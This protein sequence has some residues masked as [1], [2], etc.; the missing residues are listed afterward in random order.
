MARRSKKT[1]LNA[2]LSPVANT[3]TSFAMQPP[4]K[5]RMKVSS[6]ALRQIGEEPRSNRRRRRQISQV[7][8]EW[9]SEVMDYTEKV[10]ELGGLVELQANTLSLCAFPVRRWEPDTASWAANDPIYDDPKDESDDPDP[11]SETP[12]KSDK[13]DE[14]PGNVMR[15]FVGPYGGS[16]QLV[17][18]CAY[19][20][21]SA[22]ETQLFAH[23]VVDEELLWEFL[24]VEE[25]RL[26]A[27]GT[28]ARYENGMGARVELKEGTDDFYVARL[29]LPSPRYSGLATSQ[30]KRVLPILQEIVTLTMMVDA[31]AKSRVSA[32]LLFIPDELSFAADPEPQI[33]DET[34][35][36]GDP[37]TP[38]G[39]LDDDDAIDEDDLVDELFDHMTAP[40][41]DPSSAARIVPIV[42][43]GK[44]EYGQ[45]IQ[46]I[47]LARELDMWA[48]E[49]R[50]EA[51]GR[52]AQGLDAPPEAMRGKGSANH[53]TA[54]NIDSEFIVKHIQPIGR[55]IAAFLTTAYLRPM[56][57]AY[58]DMTEEEAENFMVEF[59]PSPV[60]ARADE[61]K[62]ARDL[63][64][65]LSDEA[66]LAANGFSKADM[67]SGEEVRQRRLWELIRDQGSIYGK[68]LPFLSGFSDID[69]EL[70]GQV[71]TPL[72]NEPSQE[73]SPDTESKVDQG[74]AGDKTKGDK[75]VD[76]TSGTET[77]DK[78]TG[79]AI[80]EWDPD[81]ALLVER[82]TTAA[83]QAL[84][85]A[86]ERA[87]NKVVS[88]FQ[89]QPEVKLRLQNTAKHRVLASL[90][91]DE[92]DKLNGGRRKLIDGSWDE[93]AA[94]T[95]TWLTDYLLHIGVPLNEAMGR[96]SEATAALVARL[97]G[98][99]EAG[100]FLPAK[101]GVNG[102]HVAN[103]LVADVVEMAVLVGQPA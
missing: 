25:L 63:S 97:N 62:S 44:G 37:A 10:G 45:Y 61:A 83:D 85:R 34:D 100:L 60:I 40:L 74:Q 69:P 17:F 12:K 49:L 65:W 26:E 47:S 16:E 77:P 52:L 67:A 19:H 81:V 68:L 23:K 89:K 30:C 76:K 2:Q 57:V 58:E 31:V 50:M 94:T 71:G 93:Y 29:H 27:D 35:E 103:E 24:S 101:R 51:L 43:R 56:L 33:D 86:R 28:Y 99:A 18:T 5:S 11:T 90:T 80:S 9:Q 42:I 15:A 96:A 1:T 54:A 14:R 88:F 41:T 78:P 53:W 39:D 7:D 98:H 6:A 21:Y 66:L 102:L 92:I 75:V 8:R 22:G 46:V 36:L 32:N 13:Y 73:E 84:L 95:Q 3:V 91:S 87:T 48:Q 55:R 4:T 82:I 79:L 64:D 72:N 59:D 38:P 70:I 20:L